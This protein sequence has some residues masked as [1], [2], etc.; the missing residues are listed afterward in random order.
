MYRYD[1]STALGYLLN[2]GLD[3]WVW[4]GEGCGR[5]GMGDR[6]MIV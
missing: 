2:V 4:R 5:E 3:K 6:M 1:I